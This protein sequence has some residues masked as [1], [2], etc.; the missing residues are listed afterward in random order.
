MGADR[1][2]PSMISKLPDPPVAPT[3]PHRREFH[4]EVVE[5]DLAWLIDKKDP[6]VIKHLKAENEYADAVMAPMADLQ[7]KIFDEIKARTQETDLSVPYRKGAW[8][9]FSRTEE[10]KPYRIHCRRADDGTGRAMLDDEGAEEVLLDE[11]ELAEGH[12]YLSVGVAAVS[13]DGRRLAYSID[14]EGDEA[15][16]LHVKDLVTGEVLADEIT[17]TSYSLAWAADSGSFFYT[18]LDPA[19]R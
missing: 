13:P 15:Y 18:T 6:A 9:Y 2:V 4:G 17:N 19:Q 7:Q 8:W 14:H 11:N 3:R 16:V 12:D 5:D 1:I 10:G